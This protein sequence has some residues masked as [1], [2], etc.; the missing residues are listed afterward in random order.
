MEQP[1]PGPRPFACP[2][3]IPHSRPPG[4]MSKRER[5]GEAIRR[6]HWYM[7]ARH[8]RWHWRRRGKPTCGLGCVVPSHCP[9]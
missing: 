6:S 3:G 2:S 5:T 8:R 4:D 1:I 7:H 9:S